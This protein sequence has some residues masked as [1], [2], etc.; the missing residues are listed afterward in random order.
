MFSLNTGRWQMSASCTTSSPD[1]PG[2]S[3]LFTSR[4]PMM[5]QRRRNGLTAWNWMG[6]ESGWTSPS[7]RDLTPRPLESTWEGQRTVEAVP[8]VLDATRVTMTGAT[9]ADTTEVAMI[10][11]TTGSTTDHTEGDPHHR[12]T[13]ERTGPG[14][15]HG[16]ILL[17]DID[18]AETSSS[19]SSPRA[20]T[21]NVSEFDL[22]SYS[23]RQHFSSLKYTF[24]AFRCRLWSSCF[25]I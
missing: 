2:A 18:R 20:Q 7:Q 16:L 5:L 9:I 3:L 15:D 19:S 17:V 6:V 14:P 25:L 12:T 11:M 24:E 1:V 21:G 23:D 13:E 22:L 10:A 4:T 8:V